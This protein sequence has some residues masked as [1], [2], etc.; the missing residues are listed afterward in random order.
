[1]ENSNLKRFILIFA[2]LATFCAMLWYFTDIFV[3]MF[4]A[5]ILAILGSP[6][7]RLLQ[8]IRI[9][10]HYLPDSVAAGITLAAIVAVMGVLINLLIPLVSY[11][12]R[13]LQNIDFTA[14][15]DNLERACRSGFRDQSDHGRRRY[16]CKNRSACK[17][18]DRG[19][20][21]L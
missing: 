20:S 17:S 21:R 13:Q 2:V 19:S 8:K 5:L 4:I 15:M 1:M 3:Y 9:G 12:I 14:L 7:V 11:E 10:K 6:L 16:R 18:V